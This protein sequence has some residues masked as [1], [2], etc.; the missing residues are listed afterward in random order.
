MAHS[1]VTHRCFPHDTC[2]SLASPAVSP[3]IPTI[4]TIPTSPPPLD[5]ARRWASP[6]R[7]LPIP[8]IAGTLAVMRHLGAPAQL[9][10]PPPS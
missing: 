3:T 5:P 1:P 7:R 10:R 6:M 9:S 8:R 2:L 4:P